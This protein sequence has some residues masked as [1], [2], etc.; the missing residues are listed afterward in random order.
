[1]ALAER[2]PLVTGLILGGV[3]A[4]LLG[5]AF[6]PFDLWGLTLL[7]VVPLGVLAWETP[8]P[9]R[10]ALGAALAS[11]PMWAFH[12][13]WIAKVSPVGFPV[14]ILYLAVWPG[15]FVWLAA[16]VHRRRRAWPAWAIVP[17]LW[18]GLEVLRGEVIWHGYPWYLLSH[19][20]ADLLWLSTVGGIIGAYGVGTIVATFAGILVQAWATRRRELVDVQRTDWLR[21]IALPVV[22]VTLIVGMLV[23]TTSRPATPPPTVRVAVVQTNVPQDNRQSWSD[24]ERVRDFLSFLEMTA[25]AADPA[26]GAIPDVIVWPET[27]FAGST[28][29]VEAVATER[30]AGLGITQF[31]DRLVSDQRRLGVPMIV[32]AIGLDG[33][34]VSNTPEGIEY[35]FDARFNSAFVVRG[36]AV[37]PNRYDKLHLTPFGEVMP[38]IS[39]WPW[40]EQRLLALGAGGMT[41]DLEAGRRPVVLEVPLNS[42]ESERTILRVATPICFEATMPA[43]C[44]QL[45]APGGQRA[46]D[47]MVN[48]TNDGWVAWFDASR[49]NHLLAARWRCIE[50]GTP[51]V[52]AANT[53]I[54]CAIGGD[55]RIIT[56]ED[57]SGRR[58]ASLSARTAGTLTV[59]V[60]LPDER[61]TI[62][63]RHGH[64][65][66]W[67]VMMGAGVMA[68]SGMVPQPRKGQPGP[69]TRDA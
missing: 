18:T 54:S 56:I 35:R 9:A 64:R 68:L 17:V 39:A 1:M 33:L 67:I 48:L 36:G 28:L 32:G 4:L 30:A 13:Q 61:T 34:H 27:M 45:V 21:R 20:T 16:R 50:L 40:L 5:L 19:P 52:R 22:A 60:P 25:Q 26:D 7:A 3:H 8:R 63:A 43:V 38:Y 46:A 31:H 15:L 2:K 66:G 47:L 29:S 14:L 51:M 69:T 12:H 53:G 59:D 42:G 6:A 65:W 41:F 11:I 49:R 44:R 10:A 37:D 57:G 24:D 55:G 58:P 23:M 62:Y